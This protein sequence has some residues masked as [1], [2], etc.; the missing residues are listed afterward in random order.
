MKFKPY[1]YSKINTFSSCPRKFKFKYIDKIKEPHEGNHLSKGKLVHLFLEHQ[2]DKAKIKATKD[3]RELLP[4]LKE[5]PEIMRES[6]KIYNNFKGSKLGKFIDSKIPMFNE[7]AVGLDE[8]MEIQEYDSD[9]IIFRGYIDK[10]VRDGDTLFLID[11]KTGRY[12][13][14]MSW[15]QLLYYGVSLFS[16][17]PSDKIVM[18]NVFV[19]HQKF[20][21][22]VLYRTDIKKYQKALMDKIEKIEMD[23]SFDKNETALCDWCGYRGICS[24]ES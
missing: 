11:Y 15:E 6:V 17:M 12:R 18:M 10:I 2:G 19:E 14:D 5:N 16:K 24:K 1:S 7:L 23:K 22:E 9:D 3:F 8:N 4:T 13:P 20:N 21:K